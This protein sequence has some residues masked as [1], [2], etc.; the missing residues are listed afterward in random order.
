M[1]EWPYMDMDTEHTL[2]HRHFNS[3]MSSPCMGGE[4]GQVLGV[5]AMYGWDD[6]GAAHM[7]M[8]GFKRV[9]THDSFIKWKE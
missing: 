8:G 7:D 1:G 5:Y 9:C 3:R 6:M 4:M 2:F